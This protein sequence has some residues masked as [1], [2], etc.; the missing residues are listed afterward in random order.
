MVVSQG[1]LG[2]GLTSVVGAI[3]AEIFQGRHYGSIFGIITIALIGIAD[4]QFVGRNHP[5]SVVRYPREL[6]SEPLQRIET[7]T[8]VDQPFHFVLVEPC[9]DRVL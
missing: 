7:I 4:L 6:V 5:T 9:G 1:M 2:Y 8:P 3:P